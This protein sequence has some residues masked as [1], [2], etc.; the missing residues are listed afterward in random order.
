MAI[1]VEEAQGHPFSPGDDVGSRAVSIDA[2]TGA[3]LLPAF[4]GP[5]CLDCGNLEDVHGVHG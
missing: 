3:E 1:V 4:E 5:I 2:E